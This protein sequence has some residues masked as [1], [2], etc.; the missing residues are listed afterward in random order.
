MPSGQLASVAIVNLSRPVIVLNIDS[1]FP[2][3]K[4]SHL[5]KYT[6]S[7]LSSLPSPFMNLK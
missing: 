2:E 1:G 3:I 5:L 7:N 4:Q 6:C